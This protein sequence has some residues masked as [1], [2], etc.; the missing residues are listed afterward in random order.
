M[1]VPDDLI[2]EL[3]HFVVEVVLSQSPGAFDDR[4]TQ[5]QS[6]QHLQIEGKTLKPSFTF[7]MDTSSA[8][9]CAIIDKLSLQ[10]DEA[11]S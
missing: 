7:K 6:L 8:N 4:F 5:M 1:S 11:C 10:P 3:N 9:W 2:D